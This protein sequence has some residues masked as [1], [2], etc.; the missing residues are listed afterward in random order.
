MTAVEETS[1]VI[2][3]KKQLF[4]CRRT[5]CY[6]RRNNSCSRR[7]DYSSLYEVPVTP[8]TETV[9]PVTPV[10]EPAIETVV[11][12]HENFIPDGPGQPRK[13]KNNFAQKLKP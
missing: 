11:P 6:N 4:S 13:M 10:Q 7:T 12:D 1:V 3:L 5:S 2:P 8:V 9:P